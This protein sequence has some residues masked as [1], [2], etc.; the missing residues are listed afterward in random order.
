[1]SYFCTIEF[2]KK[3]YQPEANIQ[4]LYVIHANMASSLARAYDRA[5]SP[6]HELFQ[7]PPVVNSVHLP[8]AAVSGCMQS[9]SGDQW[10]RAAVLSSYPYWSSVILA[11]A[12]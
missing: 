6:H 10:S 4:N 2:V 11:A 3:C 8:S 12:V 9:V 7:W 1:M 5:A